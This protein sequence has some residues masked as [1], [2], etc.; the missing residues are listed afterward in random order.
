MTDP[1]DDHIASEDCA[2]GT[3]AGV[4]ARAHN[5]ATDALD[6]LG[7]RDALGPRYA[8]DSRDARDTV[9]PIES[10]PIGRLLSTAARL[11]E[12]AWQEALEQRDLTH[13]GLITLHLLDGGALDQT[14]LA[15]R[16]RVEAQTMSRTVDR[17]ER[18][19]LVARTSDPADRRRRHIVRTAS[20]DRAL[21]ATRALEAEV[22]PAVGDPELVRYSLLEIIHAAS[23]DRWGSA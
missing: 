10:W 22:F 16:A 12:H 20:G 2:S 15:H 3:T 17:L 19:G 23:R 5:A 14:E 6:P 21:E 18:S 13:A 9:D 1:A 11:V 7:P 4:R 8:L